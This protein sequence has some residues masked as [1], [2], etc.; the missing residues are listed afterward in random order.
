MV[1]SIKRETS[2][3]M[4]V[5]AEVDAMGQSVISILQ[6]PSWT[7]EIHQPCERAVQVLC[8]SEHV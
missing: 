3:E 6:E 5:T 7:F 4:K 2:I 1:W 8:L